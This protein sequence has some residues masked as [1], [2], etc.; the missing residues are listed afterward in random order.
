[1][2]NLSTKVHDVQPI[3]SPRDNSWKLPPS[4]TIIEVEQGHH[5]NSTKTDQPIIINL[6]QNESAHPRL[7]KSANNQMVK[8]AYH[9][10]QSTPNTGIYWDKSTTYHRS[11]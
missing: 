6:S 7:Q 1:M 8:H 4:A 2:I 5:H 3:L 9:K 10:H 11:S